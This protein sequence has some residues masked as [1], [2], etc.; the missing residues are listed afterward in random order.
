[1]FGDLESAL[2]SRFFESLRETKIGWKNHAKLGFVIHILAHFCI[3]FCSFTLLM[4]E[5]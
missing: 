3:F 1:M 4:T 5:K 2:E